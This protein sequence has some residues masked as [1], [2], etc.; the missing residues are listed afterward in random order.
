MGAAIVIVTNTV[1][2]TIS[3]CSEENMIRIASCCNRVIERLRETAAAPCVT[4]GARRFA[5]PK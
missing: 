4:P 2:P 5:Y 3:G 1:T